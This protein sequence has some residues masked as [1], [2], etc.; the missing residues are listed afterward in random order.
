MSKRD[1]ETVGR[2]TLVQ[3]LFDRG[4][5]QDALVRDADGAVW[6]L[7]RWPSRTDAV[8]AGQLSTALDVLAALGPDVPDAATELLLDGFGDAVGFVR[9]R[10]SGWSVSSRVAQDGPMAP[11][12][13]LWL[14]TAMLESLGRLRARTPGL[15][16][17][18]IDPASVFLTD[19]P[20]AVCITGYPTLRR[21]V[22]CALTPA[23]EGEPPWTDCVDPAFAPPELRIGNHTGPATDLYGI[24]AVAL[25][26]LTG[27]NPRHFSGRIAELEQVLV[28]GFS[29]PRL[30]ARFLAGALS[31]TVEE[32]YETVEAALD[33][34]SGRADA[35]AQ[36]AAAA[37]VAAAAGE[38]FSPEPDKVRGQV[39]RA[40]ATGAL[41]S[42]PYLLLGASALARTGPF[43][44][45]LPVWIAL[46]VA[47]LGV[48]GCVANLAVLVRRARAE[49]GRTVSL[50]EFV[51]GVEGTTL[52]GESKWTALRDARVV[53]GRI[54]LV[55][56]WSN[57]S[58]GWL[59]NDQIDL[60]D[61]YSVSPE[62]LVERIRDVH[63]QRCPEGWLTLPDRPVRSW[64]PWWLAV[65]AGVVLV[66]WLG[67]TGTR[68]LVGGPISAD[69]AATVA[70][71]VPVD[72]VRKEPWRAFALGEMDDSAAQRAQEELRRAVD[73][74][75]AAEAAALAEGEAG[76][77][78][79][80][81]DCPADMQEFRLIDSE[82]LPAACL[83]GA[84]VMVKAA[85][86]TESG[87]EWFLVDW[88]ET[89]A[90]SYIACAAGGNCPPPLEDPGCRSQLSRHADRPANCVTRA[91]AE[92]YCAT[93]GRRLCT[94]D[95][96]Y[97]AAGAIAVGDR[98]SFPTGEPDCRRA[99]I[100]D[101]S[102]PGCGEE[103]TAPLASR[104]LGASRFGAVDIVGNV[105]EMTG[106]GDRV[107]GGSWRSAPGSSGGLAS[108]EFVSG[109]PARDVGFRCC[110]DLPQPSSP[111]DTP[112][113]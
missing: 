107:L 92:A 43:P 89:S 63:D 85:R 80:A 20:R 79:A 23:S 97:A 7:T 59:A 48:L 4:P 103:D 81:G 54:E 98:T 96:W 6:L 76:L 65:P 100:R 27:E 93:A 16:H 19:T 99:V 73:A 10:A 3:V 95:E 66:G 2:F 111:A 83:D 104:P 21:A 74:I 1:A 101:A 109:R 86:A 53:E 102:G 39:I 52:R 31:P 28:A 67:G 110:R 11:A 38:T 32:R 69:P 58:G 18:G 91:G 106:D 13:V 25:Y 112:T 108:L 55:G 34:I 14:T 41:L 37:A 15:L 72:A 61:V 46:M 42:V 24:A 44:A 70:G 90:R 50:K 45:D 84:G 30:L 29:A 9:P 94:T 22:S 40:G 82:N 68:V 12:D 78:T 56:A 113:P 88:T 51:L 47:T 75:A 105:A 35:R 33:V 49:S 62:R 26:A 71:V 36:Q 8:A 77:G 17:V 87:P 60:A 64:R 57:G 5:F